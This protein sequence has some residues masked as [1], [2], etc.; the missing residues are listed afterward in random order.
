MKLYAFGIINGMFLMSFLPVVAITIIAFLR[1]KKSSKTWL[2]FGYLGIGSFYWVLDSVIDNYFNLSIFGKTI[3]NGLGEPLLLGICS[4]IVFCFDY[5]CESLDK[6]TTKKRSLIC[7][8]LLYVLVFLVY[9]LMPTLP[10]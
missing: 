1:F 6:L 10:E 8:S 5:S 9:V 3:A 4:G 2:C 7:V